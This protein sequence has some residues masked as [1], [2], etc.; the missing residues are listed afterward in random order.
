MTWRD[1]DKA[2]AYIN[3][4]IKDST[5]I[6]KL[7]KHTIE[8]LLKAM[9]GKG[10]DTYTIAR[11]MQI[12]KVLAEMGLNRL[13]SLREQDIEKIKA[14][15]GSMSTST[16]RKVERVINMIKEMYPETP[17]IKFHYARDVKKYYPVIDK[18]TFYNIILPNVIEKYRDFVWLLYDTGA[19]PHEIANLKSEHVVEKHD[20]MGKYYILVLTGKTGT[21]IIRTLDFKG[22][23]NTSLQYPFGH[24]KSGSFTRYINKLEHRLN[25]KLWPYLLRHSRA[26]QLATLLSEQELKYFF[27]W[28]PSSKMLDIYVHIQG[29]KILEHLSKLDNIRSGCSPNLS[30]PT[31]SLRSQ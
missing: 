14:R 17:K 7:D 28:R 15:Y 27:G 23:I 24:I 22:D 8:N 3:N 10:M 16:K 12:L 2:L 9:A 31:N 13:S 4:K 30:T 1:K 19:R 11:Y 6:S 29:A 5:R 21:R 18:N 26:T 20:A 25:I